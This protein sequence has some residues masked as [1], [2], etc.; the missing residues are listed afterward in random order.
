MCKNLGL[1]DTFGEN[2]GYVANKIMVHLKLQIPAKNRVKIL[3]EWAKQ[4]RPHILKDTSTNSFEDGSDNVIKLPA[5]VKSK[6]EFYASWE[7]RTLRM[8]VIKEFGARCKC[9]GATPGDVDISGKPVRIVVD[10]IKPISKHWELRLSK[11]NLVPLCDE[12][13]QG[14]GAW[15]E[16]DWRGAK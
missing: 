8:Q 15:D 16:T 7:W 14:K 4:A 10:H 6:A 9:C 5:T 11:D 12:C 3:I 2:N 13:N 1:S